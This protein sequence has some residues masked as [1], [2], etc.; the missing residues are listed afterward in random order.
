MRIAVLT[1]IAAVLFAAPIHAQTSARFAP[2]VFYPTNGWS[3]AA[4][5]IADVNGDGKPD[6]V[7]SNTCA[8]KVSCGNINITTCVGC[9]GTVAVLL[10]VGDGTFQ[11]AVNYD[12]GGYGP[13]SVVVADV[14]GDG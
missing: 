12:S 4:V 2:S 7:I 14:N 13:S 9:D 5:A 10:G 3:P 6:L 1:F 8:N 11:P